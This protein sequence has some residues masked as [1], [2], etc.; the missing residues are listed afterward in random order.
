M[1]I[2]IHMFYPYLLWKVGMKTNYCMNKIKNR[3]LHKGQKE[4]WATQSVA[5]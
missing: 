5:C 1:M 3:K 4:H 2:N